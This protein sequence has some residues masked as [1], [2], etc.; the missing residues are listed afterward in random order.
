MTEDALPDGLVPADGRAI[1]L[2]PEIAHRF[3]IDAPPG[4]PEAAVD[5][6]QSAADHLNTATKGYHPDD[7]RDALFL[8]RDLRAAMETVRKVDEA[9]VRWLYLHGEHGQHQHLDGINGEFYIGR[10][11][12]KERWASAEGVREYV[13]RKIVANEGEYPDP[14]EVVEWVL[15]VLPATTSTSLRKTPLRAV[16]MDVG[17][18]LSSEPGTIKVDLPIT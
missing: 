15:E 2:T 13:A 1:P 10:G 12:S 5:L 17:D 7:W 4:T 8:L 3:G 11:R 14:S 6:F 18:Y 16:G 9:L